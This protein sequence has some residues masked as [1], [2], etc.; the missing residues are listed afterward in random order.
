MLL[1]SLFINAF[2][3]VQLT[4]RFLVPFTIAAEEDQITSTLLL[5]AYLKINDVDVPTR[6]SIDRQIVY[7]TNPIPTNVQLLLHSSYDESHSSPFLSEPAQSNYKIAKNRSFL[8]MKSSVQL[9]LVLTQTI[10]HFHSRLE[11]LRRASRCRIGLPS[12]MEIYGSCDHGKAE[13]VQGKASINT[14]SNA[15]FPDPGDLPFRYIRIWA[16]VA[17]KAPTFFVSPANQET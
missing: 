5:L 1:R 7:P 9:L 3:H 17:I 2:N 13:S 14:A 12:S 16:L 11:L 8:D 6:R 10:H 15:Y 4:L